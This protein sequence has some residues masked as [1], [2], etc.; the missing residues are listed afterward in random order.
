MGLHYG[1]LT[2]HVMQERVSEMGLLTQMKLICFSSNMTVM[3]AR[4]LNI[5]CKTVSVYFDNLRGE[6][7][8]NLRAYPIQFGDN[9]EYEVD[10]CLVKHIWNPHQRRHQVLWF[11]GSLE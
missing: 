6:W 9:G 8:D 3:A 2:K 7:L 5:S 10:E 1:A 11:S 4:L